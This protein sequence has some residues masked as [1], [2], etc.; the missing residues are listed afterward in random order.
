MLRG[1]S[2]EAPEF[3]LLHPT[4]T[5]T[6]YF[7]MMAPLRVQRLLYH[8]RVH[9]SVVLFDNGALDI[10]HFFIFRTMHGK[11]YRYLLSH[12]PAP[13]LLNDKIPY[14]SYHTYSNT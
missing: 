14:I 6:N 5:T 10:F 12:Q 3:L 8:T 9:R 13:F 1:T 2:G 4:T 7:T 11:Q